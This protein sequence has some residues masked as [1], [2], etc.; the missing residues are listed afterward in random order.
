MLESIGF[1][2]PSPVTPHMCDVDTFSLWQNIGNLF[3]KTAYLVDNEF[4]I[5]GI[6]TGLMSSKV[7]SLPNSD[8]VLLSN[9]TI[10]YDFLS[11]KS[12]EEDFR[13]VLVK[14]KPAKIPDKIS[15]IKISDDESRESVQLPVHEVQ[16][17][18]LR[19]NMG[20]CISNSNKEHDFQLEM[21]IEF[22]AYHSA[23]GV[24]HFFYYTKG[25]TDK[26]GEAISLLQ[27]SLDIS[28]QIIPWNSPINDPSLDKVAIKLDCLLQSMGR[29]QWVALLNSSD[30]IYHSN[31]FTLNGLLRRSRDSFSV[32]KVFCDC[33]GNF[34]NSTEQIQILKVPN[35]EGLQT[36]VEILEFPDCLFLDVVTVNRC[37]EKLFFHKFWNFDENLRSISHYFLTEYYSMLTNN[38]VVP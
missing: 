6:T 16:F 38:E 18:Y 1:Y 20:I 19:N 26:L 14:C 30:I 10:Q 24:K 32:S 12:E 36:V 22:F 15:F 28:V 5:I 17:E 33:K 13:I 31:E 29:T 8:G 9:F 4:I 35:G 34:T 21:N 11:A 27:T 2:A 23:I 25:L 37:N 3:V 7:C